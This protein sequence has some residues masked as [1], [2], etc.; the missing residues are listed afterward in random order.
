M[1]ATRSEEY[2]AEREA[3]L[4]VLELGLKEWKLGF[5]RGFADRP[6]IHTVPGGNVVALH[7]AC[8]SFQDWKEYHVLLGRVWKKGVGGHGPDQLFTAARDDQVNVILQLQQLLNHPVLFG[9]DH[10]NG[11]FRNLGLGTGLA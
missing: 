9:L 3:L 7:F 11:L 10:L 2:S 8:S 4:M 6:L 1:S 5:A